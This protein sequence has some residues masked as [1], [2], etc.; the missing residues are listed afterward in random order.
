MTGITVIIKESESDNSPS[1][2]WI[3]IST[4]PLKSESNETV[5]IFPFIEAFVSSSTI[6]EYDKGSPSISSAS[7]T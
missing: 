6:Y 4:S 5:N 3:S 1:F 7:K 2:T